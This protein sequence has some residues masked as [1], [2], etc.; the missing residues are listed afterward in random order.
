MHIHCTSLA[1]DSLVH[2]SH[3]AKGFFFLKDGRSH[4]PEGVIF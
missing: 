1:I 2:V 4:N 3:T